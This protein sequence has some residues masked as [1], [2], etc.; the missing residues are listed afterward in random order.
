MVYREN[1]K[2]YGSKN[3]EVLKEVIRFE[4]VEILAEGKIVLNTEGFE[5][6]KPFLDGN[7]RRIT[8]YVNIEGVGGLENLGLEAL[9]E[10]Q[11]QINTAFA[12]SNGRDTHFNIFVG[13]EGSARDSQLG[14]I[15]QGP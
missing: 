7:G 8:G 15:T 2:V 3:N 13:D 14:W 10:M 6:A 9:E 5:P 1:H 12:T 11:S 4:A